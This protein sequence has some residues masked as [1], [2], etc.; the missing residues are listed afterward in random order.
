M[1]FQQISC[2]K[3]AEYEDLFKISFG[4]NKL[5]KNYLEW[6]YFENPLGQVIGY[7]AVQDG[8]VVAHYPCV[9]T[10]IDSYIGLLAL[11]NATHPNFRSQ[12][13]HQKLAYKTF[14]VAKQNFS[15][16]IAVVN[17]NSVGN[18]LNKFGFNQLGQLN[19]R[20]GLLKRQKTGVKK[21]NQ[22]EL[23]WRVKS[24]KTSFKIKKSFSGGVYINCRPKWSPVTFKSRVTLESNSTFQTIRN[25]IIPFGFTI[26]WN[27]DHKPKFYLPKR[28]KPSPLIL[29]L[30][31]LSKINIKVNSWSF[32]DFDAY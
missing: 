18:Y 25:P 6:L 4:H 21:W 16:I 13:L 29:I 3:L 11:N 24:P 8:K 28:F 1:N 17:Y 32:P 31:P 23:K 12:G 7:D 20:W 15:F 9:P 26:D 5:T 27:L 30:K 22:E 2:E 19:L 10:K 14:E